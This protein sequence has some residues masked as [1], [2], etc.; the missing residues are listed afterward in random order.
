M[1]SKCNLFPRA[2]NVIIIFAL[3]AMCIEK[4]SQESKAQQCLLTLGK[5]KGGAASTKKIGIQETWLP[6]L[7]VGTQ[8]ISCWDTCLLC[9]AHSRC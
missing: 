6:R 5:N 2:R 1:R 8:C 9:L 4:K 7:A 3:K